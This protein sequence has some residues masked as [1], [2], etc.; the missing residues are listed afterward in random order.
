MS[1]D[2]TPRRRRRIA[3][4]AVIVIVAFVGVA[5]IGA[6]GS[7]R[8]PTPAPSSTSSPTIPDVKAAEA[9]LPI[10]PEGFDET[11]AEAESTRVIDLMVRFVDAAAEGESNVTSVDVA[12]QVVPATDAAPAYF[13]ALRTLALRTGVD[14][15]AQAESLRS[16]L[17]AGGWTVRDSTVQGTRSLIALSSDPDPDR[18]WFLVI[19]ADTP[20]GAAPIIGLK[21]GSPPLP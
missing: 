12:G 14:A 8:P 19:D 10:Y 2:V 4:I 21:L 5:V 16:A 6:L 1:E 9:F 7:V 13:G 3:V 11:A 15:S 20:S 17:E 18:A